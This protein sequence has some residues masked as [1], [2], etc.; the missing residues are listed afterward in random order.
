VSGTAV[1]VNRSTDGGLTWG[2]SIVVRRVGVGQDFDKNW[3]VCDST[4]SSPFYGNCYV[5]YDDAGSGNA[6]HMARSTDGGLT[7]NESSV[8]NASVIGGQPVVRPDGTVVVPIDNG[9]ASSLISTV[10]TNG[11]ASYSGI[12]PITGITDHQ[13]AGGL[14]SDALPSAEVDGAGKV[15][16]VWQ[17]CRFRP[18]CRSNDIVI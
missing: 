15:Y 11:G 16:V 10:S 18:G 1:V 13:V 9:S 4:P 14:R 3:I 7:W 2:N 12:V 8:P 17:D 6:L 5:E